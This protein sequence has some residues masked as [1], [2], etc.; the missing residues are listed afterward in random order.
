MGKPAIAPHPLAPHRYLAIHEGLGTLIGL[1]DGV[2][3]WSAGNPPIPAA[4]TFGSTLEIA[5]LAR[6]IGDELQPVPVRASRLVLATPA[7]CQGAK[8]PFWNPGRAALDWIC[9]ACGCTDSMGCETEEGP[10]SWH[11]CNDTYKL[12]LCSACMAH[13]DAWNELQASLSQAT[14]ALRPAERSTATDTR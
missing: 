8:A 2:P 5:L 1:Q 10:C 11:S 14:Q 9:I 4:I 13:L 3:A 6:A 12:G 7:D